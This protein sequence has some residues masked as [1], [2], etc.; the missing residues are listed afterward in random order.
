MGPRTNGAKVFLCPMHPEVRQPNPGKCSKCGMN[1]QL[2]GTR[3][4]LL[5]HML[6]NPFHLLVMAGLMAVVMAVATMMMR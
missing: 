1:L 2:E 4:G 5:R 3:F 6:S